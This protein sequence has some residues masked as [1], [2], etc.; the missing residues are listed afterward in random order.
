MSQDKDM[1]KIFDRGL[2]PELEWTPDLWFIEYFQG[3][4]SYG[5]RIKETLCSEKSDYQNIAIYDTYKHGRM[6][7]IDGLV[8]LTELDEFIYHEMIVH[9]PMQTLPEAKRAAV[10]GGGDGG[11]V[12]ELLKY[13]ELEKITL[14][15][16]DKRVVETCKEHLPSVASG[17][18][19]P[20]VE[21]L[22]EDGAQY[23][24][25]VEPESL[26]LLII[27]STD[28]IGPGQVL[29][30]EEFYKNAAKALAGHGVLTAQTETP[31]YHGAIVNDIYTNLGRA[32][33]ETWMYWA[34]IPA[35][36]GCIWT[37]S[38]VSKSKHPIE[39][40]TPR[41]IDKLAC[42][43]YTPSLHRAAFSPPA[44]AIKNLPQG[45]PQRSQ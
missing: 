19:D 23:V 42:N 5:L 17:L 20:R 26:D 28:P 6:L 34:A 45:H 38:Y 18:S 3:M 30:T 27:D 4:V 32:F 31:L 25:K 10:I 22:F 33:P 9:V 11:T 35:Y 37:F 15:E 12:R 24:K 29:F 40:Q 36:L 2:D 16:I 13:P 14:I 41:H 21:V 43:Y 8:M 7:T 1:E 44:M 39:D